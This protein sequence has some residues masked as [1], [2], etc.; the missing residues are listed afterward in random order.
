[1]TT[2]V[3]YELTMDGSIYIAKAGFTTKQQANQWIS[4]H[5]LDYR[6]QRAI[7]RER[8]KVI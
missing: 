2:Y 7:R 1:M 5:Q 6:K 8:G 3:V 4:E